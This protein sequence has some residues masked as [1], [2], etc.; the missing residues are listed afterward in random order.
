MPASVRYKRLPGRRLGAVRRAS[1]WDAG[2][3]LLSVSGTTFSERYRRFYYRDIQSIVMQNGP[4]LGSIGALLLLFWC[5]LTFAIVVAGNTLP[6]VFH[7]LWI[8]PVVWLAFI[9]YQSLARSCRVHI[10]TAVSSEE[11]PALFRRSAARKAVAHILTRIQEVQGSFIDVP[12]EGINSEPVTALPVPTESVPVSG[13][14]LASCLIFFFLIL[15]SAL[16]A[17]WYSRAMLTPTALFNAKVIFCVLNALEVISGVL[18][19]PALMKSQ[20]LKTVR[21]FIVAGLGLLAL[22]TYALL[23]VLYALGIRHDIYTVR[24]RQWIGTAD[25]AVSILIAFAGLISLAM[26]WQD[27]RRGSASSL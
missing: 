4:R 10:Y 2:E 24:I 21:A 25:C 11:L 3:Y 1:V 22:R 18:S 6:A 15:G 26:T 7:L 20:L 23:M 27:D 9:V 19:L 8:T 17:F 16:F 14:A 5:A 12:R 13:K